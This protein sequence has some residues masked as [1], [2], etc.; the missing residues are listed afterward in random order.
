MNITSMTDRF[1][2][3][4]KIFFS[5][6]RIIV[7]ACIL[8]VIGYLLMAGSADSDIFS[9]RRIVAAPVLCLSGYLIIIAGILRK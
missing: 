4:A 8:I 2:A 1:I 6:R 7:F 9:P 5:R 3:T